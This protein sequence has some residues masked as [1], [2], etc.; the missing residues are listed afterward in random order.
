MSRKFHIRLNE[1]RKRAGYS[2]HY[3]ARKLAISEAEYEEYEKGY[4]EPNLDMLEAIADALGCSLDQLFGRTAF[5]ARPETWA[6]RVC[7]KEQVY[8]K[9]E[10]LAYTG[11]K[12]LEIGTEDFRRWRERGTYYVDKTHMISEFLESWYQVT[13]VTRP[14][15]FGKTLNMS[16]LAEFLDCTKDS[17]A[18]F[19]GTKIAGSGW[20]EQMNQSPVIFL[21]FL[22]VDANSA[23]G[24]LLILR[25]IIQQEYRRHALALLDGKLPKK[26]IEEYESRYKQLST[27][28]NVE[29]LEHELVDSIRFLSQLLKLYYGKSVYI[30]IDEYD[31]PFMSANSGGYYEKVRKTLSEILSVSLKGNPYLEKAMLT[32]IQRVAKENAFSGLNNLAVCTVK[33]PEYGDCFGF[34]EN[35][36]KQLFANFNVEFSEEIRKMYN[37]YQF[38]EEKVYNPWSISN[39]VFRKKLEPYW[40]HTAENGI[41]K[42]ALKE[43]GTS[44]ER[45]YQRLIRNGEVTVKVNLSTAYYEHQSD[46][47][48]W[49]LLVN[50]GML[51]IAQDLGDDW[52]KVRVPNREVWTAFGELTAAALHVEEE[53]WRDIFNCLI[54]GDMEGFAENYREVVWK[55]PS[56]HDL[57][58]E[59]S[60]HMMVLGMCVFLQRNYEVISN[61]EAGEGR[62]DIVLKPKREDLT[63][64]IFEFK[65]TKDRKKDLDIL[66][67][68][69][70]DQIVDKRYK[71]V[72][73][74]RPI[75]AVGLAHRGK[76]TA[77]KWKKV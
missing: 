1:E 52:Y 39:Y 30:L 14:R 15:R 64:I 66:A 73:G 6:D 60:Y 61:R 59:N 70:L 38:G 58:D 13:L 43:C 41:L 53:S 75:L 37:G 36:V 18:L 8:G 68:D 46:A 44:F 67:A 69:G 28:D 50:T 12:K 42:N 7:E 29:Q 27:E 47:A 51:T 62:G 9:Q 72:L 3:M 40:I 45:N 26:E 77:V 63:G 48:L 74:E 24:M 10:E 31:K 2:K 35:E 49:G 32:G 76:E 5:G 4:Q 65:Y 21:S 57:K 56:Y 23:K 20:M 34:T 71:T 22:N 55:L 54:R 17:R 25:D 11:S 16:M 19:V 33:D